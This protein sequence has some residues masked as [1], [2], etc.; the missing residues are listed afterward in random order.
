MS[1]AVRA[2]LIALLAVAAWQVVRVRVMLDTANPAAAE[3]ARMKARLGA[4]PLVL[5]GGAY[6]GRSVP[7]PEW[8]VERSGADAH[9]AIAYKDAAGN[10]YRLYI[11]GAARATGYFH[12]PDGCMPSVGW[13]IVEKRDVPFTLFPTSRPD[14]AMRR[15]V[16]NYGQQRMAV[17]Y[18]FQAGGDVSPNDLASSYFRFRNILANRLTSPS[19]VVT[20]YVSSAGYP[21]DWEGRAAAFLSAVAPAIQ[22]ALTKDE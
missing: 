13:E 2:L 16:A 1:A 22:T 7:E 15:L 19:F 4:L 18:W 17:Y 5:G 3:I 20:V 11:G 8:I 6:Q 12:K 21:D 9:A 10:D 14:A